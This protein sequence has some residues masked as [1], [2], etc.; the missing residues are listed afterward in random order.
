MPQETTNVF[1]TLKP[2]QISRLQTSLH[3]D[4]ISMQATRTSEERER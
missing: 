2:L 4:N 1:T 3:I